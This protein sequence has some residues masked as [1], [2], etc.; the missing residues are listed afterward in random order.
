MTAKIGGWRE[1]QIH[2]VAN[3]FPLMPDAA[4]QLFRADIEARGL[5]TSKAERRKV[6]A[7]LA[8]AAWHR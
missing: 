8:D 3:L 5:K 2:P 7:M 1:L 6:G 4:F